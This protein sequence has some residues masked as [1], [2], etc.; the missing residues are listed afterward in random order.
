MWR[1]KMLQRPDGTGGLFISCPNIMIVI[2]LLST[3]H[4][5]III[6]LQSKSK[7]SEITTYGLHMPGSL[8]KG[9]F[10]VSAI[11]FDFLLLA[12]LLT[13]SNTKSS[14]DGCYDRTII[15][16]QLC[17]FIAIKFLIFNGFII[18]F[19]INDSFLKDFFS[20]V[21]NHYVTKSW[22]WEA[23]MYVKSKPSLSESIYPSFISDT[24]LGIISARP[25][26]E[27]QTSDQDIGNSLQY[28]HY[29][30]HLHHKYS[31]KR[32]H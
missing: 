14:Y 27:H 31:S 32:V 5:N 9:F 18:F 28:S 21:I 25:Q 26:T 30:Y 19:F 3:Y 17:T 15:F 22:D 12:R 4:N 29:L 13:L 7:S 23:K 10:S 16:T 11:K 2:T 8:W 24:G 1:R 20:S 6:K